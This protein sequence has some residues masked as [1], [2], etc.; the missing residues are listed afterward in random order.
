MSWACISRYGGVGDN[1]IASSVLAPLRTKYGRVEVITQWPQ[2]VVFENNPHIDKLSVHKPGDIPGETLE[3]WARWHRVRAKEY[4]FFANLSHTVEVLKAFLP[5]QTQF[6]WPVAW[7]REYCAGSYIEAVAKVCGVDPADC[8]PRFF[9]TE[10]EHAKAKATFGEQIGKRPVIGWVLSGSRVD[11]IH[12]AGTL[13]VA[14]LI[15]E[16]GAQVVMFGAPGRDYDMAVRIQEHVKRQNG[17]TN[18]LHSMCDSFQ[19]DMTFENQKFPIRRI[20]T[21]LRYCDLVISPDTGPAWAVAMEDVPK[22]IL[23]SHASAEN[24]TGG[25]R[26]TVTLHADRHRVPC[27]PCH[28]LHDTLDTCTPDETKQAAACISSISVASIIEEAAKIL[29]RADV[30]ASHHQRL[31]ADQRGATNGSQGT[32]RRTRG[33]QPVGNGIGGDSLSGAA[34]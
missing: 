14:R 29:A 21:Q 16:L 10:E 31:A 17:T 32:Q 3:A 18:G 24:I 8:E 15:A 26:N 4:D 2:H 9:P 19:P 20:L 30:H 23:V 7:R 5:A 11:K 25:W 34:T 12:P 27:W 1:L 22:I 33:V 28:Q 13:I 6:D